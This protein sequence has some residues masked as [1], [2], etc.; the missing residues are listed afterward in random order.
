MEL[1]ISHNKRISFVGKTRTGKSVLCNHLLSF[2]QHKKDLQII[3]I[4]PKH[5]R[6]IFGDG[7]TYDKPK[8]VESYNSKAKV[9]VFQQ[10]RWGENLDEMV[11]KILKRGNAIV[12]LE[13]L[14]G[15][16]SATQVPDGIV[17]LATQGGGKSVGLWAQ[18][19]KPTGVPKVIKSQSEYFFLFRL[20][21]VEDRKDML[22]YIPDD[23]ILK[24]IDKYFFWLYNDDMDIAVLV[25]PL[26]IKTK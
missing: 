14:G 24:K 3:I 18:Y 17:R 1:G 9:Q 22:N 23:S 4:D 8:L 2:F 21:P 11:D 20:N 25:K 26:E 15:I 6:R 13:E 10:Y 7:K 16:A 19:Q 5:E 12:S